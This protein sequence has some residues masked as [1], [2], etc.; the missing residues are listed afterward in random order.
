[1]A[2]KIKNIEVLELGEK[3]REISS[4]WS[5]TILLVKLTSDDG[6]VGYGEAPTTLMT[7]PVKESMEEVKRVFQDADFFN[8]EKN[9]KDYQ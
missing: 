1:M 7:L 9:L 3:G 8:V 4:P 6:L 2:S 5:S